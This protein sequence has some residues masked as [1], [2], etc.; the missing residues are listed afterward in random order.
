MAANAAVENAGDHG[1]SG[2][3][4]GHPEAPAKEGME[5]EGFGQDFGI[6]LQVT[7]GSKDTHRHRQQHEGEVDE[8][9]GS[10]VGVA[11]FAVAAEGEEADQQRQQTAGHRH[12]HQALHR[13]EPVWQIL[14]DAKVIGEEPAAVVKISRLRD[15]TVASQPQAAITRL[16]S[17]EQE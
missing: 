13:L 1:H 14:L 15:V 9:A 4:H 7:F 12:R 10:L 11:A 5:G 17:V 8:G 6:G 16:A 2:R 3:P